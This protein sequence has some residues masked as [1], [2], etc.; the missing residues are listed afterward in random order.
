M[1]RPSTHKSVVVDH[2]IGSDRGLPVVSADIEYTLELVEQAFGSTEWFVE[3]AAP[4]MQDSLAV[5][6]VPLRVLPPAQPLG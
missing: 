6:G 3:V 5:E 1:V 2:W 4:R